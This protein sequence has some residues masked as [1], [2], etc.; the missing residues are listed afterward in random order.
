MSLN[1]VTL[2]GNTTR[3]VEVKF[4]KGGTAVGQTGLA[5]NRKWKDQQGQLHEEVT[6][7]DLVLWGKTADFAAK[8]FDKGAPMLVVGRL[9]NE[10]WVDKQ[11]QQKRTKVVVVVDEV[12][13][14]GQKRDGTQ[15]AEGGRQAAA[16]AETENLEIQ[17]ENIPF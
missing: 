12:K 10:A 5:M 4:T 17:E 7:I 2:M 8:Y 13:F 14:C 6:F 11:T 3:P 15:K 16:P 9:K 1:Q